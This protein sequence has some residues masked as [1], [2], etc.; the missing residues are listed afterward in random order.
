MSEAPLRIGLYGGAFDPPHRAHRVLAEAALGQLSLDRLLILPT[1]QAWHKAR[2]LTAADHRLAMCQ[3]AFGDMPGVTVDDREMHRG[4]PTYTIDTVRDVLSEHPGARIFL[5][6]GA[7]QLQ[8]FRSW[9]RWAELLTLVTLAVAGRA[10]QIGEDAMS[11]GH[12]PRNLEDIGLPHVRI[13]M[14]LI[15]VSATALRLR[16]AQAG[17]AAVPGDIPLVSPAV[18]GYISQQHLYQTHP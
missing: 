8:A 12:P 1:G 9:H 16:L 18:A 15:N 11:D 10:E 6:I 13:R 4:G 2:Q 5:V 3:L 17:A 7:D 14:P